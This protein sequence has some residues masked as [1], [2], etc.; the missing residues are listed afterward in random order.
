MYVVASVEPG[1]GVND[2]AVSA[3]CLIGTPWQSPVPSRFEHE[4]ALSS[5][6]PI[7]SAS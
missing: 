2:L 4:N 1:G 3:S 7:Y 6:F 5:A